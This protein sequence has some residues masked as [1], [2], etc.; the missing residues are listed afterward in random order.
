M[1]VIE[2]NLPT[3]Y[4]VD[5]NSLPSHKDYD[6]LKQVDVANGG[7]KVEIYFDKVGYNDVY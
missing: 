6:T 7:T 3:G 2:M 1:A 5:S 4:L